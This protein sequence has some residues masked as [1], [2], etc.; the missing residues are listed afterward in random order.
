LS[1]SGGD[2][3]PK[4]SLQVATLGGGCFWCLDAVFSELK[5]V[6]S[7]VSGYSG[8]HVAN[9]TYEMVCSDRTGHAEVVQISF[10]PSVI[11][12]GELLD[13]FFTIHDPT[14]PNRQGDDVGTQYRSMILY[15]D[16]RQKSEAEGIIRRV[17]ASGMWDKEIVTE[18]EP[19]KAFYPA[20][21]YHQGYFKKNPYQ[22][23]C[24]VVIAP[25]VAKLRKKYLEKLKQ[26]S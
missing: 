9:P 17:N 16:A 23:Y 24:R 20:E 25:K 3:N 2:K 13:V 7:V 6:H 14:T 11:S 8:G 1:N 22:P 5:G 4:P 21:D 18:L 26:G 15:H 10:D 19:L 12:Y